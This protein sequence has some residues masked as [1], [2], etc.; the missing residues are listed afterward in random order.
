MSEKAQIRKLKK[1]LISQL[2]NGDW[3]KN[4]FSKFSNKYL[5]FQQDDFGW[6]FQLINQ[7]DLRKSS[8]SI[9]VSDILHPLHFWILRKFYVSRSIKNKIERDKLLNISKKAENFFDTNVEINRDN[10]LNEILD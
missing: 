8:S 1:F 2:K 4:H 3:E 6:S 5:I 10:K 9:Q 7:S